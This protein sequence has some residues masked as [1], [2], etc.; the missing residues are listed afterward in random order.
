MGWKKVQRTVG[1]LAYLNENGSQLGSQGG[2]NV[3]VKSCEVQATGQSINPHNLAGRL[4]TSSSNRRLILTS[5]Q[6]YF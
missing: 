1:E 6:S 2:N 4:A 5:T 3:T